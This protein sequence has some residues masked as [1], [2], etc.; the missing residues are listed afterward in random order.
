MS[1]PAAGKRGGIAEGER[2]GDDLQRDDGGAGH[3]AQK[4]KKKLDREL[5]RELMD[6]FPSSDP[7]ASSQPT[8]SEPAGDPKAK[9]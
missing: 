9:P 6:T 8:S 1:T 5:D 2:K 3:E 7:P 4:S